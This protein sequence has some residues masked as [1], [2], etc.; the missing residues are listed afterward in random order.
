[1]SDLSVTE[2]VTAEWISAMSHDL[3][4]LSVDDGFELGQLA[5]EH[6]LDHTQQQ[7]VV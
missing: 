2:I 4:V 6:V 7:R 1:V 3:N 5:F